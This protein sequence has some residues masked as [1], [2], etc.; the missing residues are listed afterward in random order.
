MRLKHQAY[1][2]LKSP[3]YLPESGCGIQTTVARATEIIATYQVNLLR[4]RELSRS[5]V[6]AKTRS[7]VHAGNTVIWDLLGTKRRKPDDSSVFEDLR[8]KRKNLLDR[9]PEELMG[10]I[11]LEL[12]AHQRDGS[13]TAASVARM[14]ADGKVK[15]CRSSVHLVFENCGYKYGPIQDLKY[16]AHRVNPILQASYKN[17]YAVA[18][19]LEEMG[20]AKIVYADETFINRSDCRSYGYTMSTFK[21]Q[22]ILGSERLSVFHAIT[23]DGL[24]VTDEVHSCLHIDKK[25]DVK[26]DCAV[27]HYIFSSV[28][29]TDAHK[30]VTAEDY[31]EYFIHRL[32]KAFKSKYPDKMMIL[33]LD[34]ALFHKGKADT[35]ISRSSSRKQLWDILRK[36]GESRYPTVKTGK[37]GVGVPIIITAKNALLTGKDCPNS[38]V[39][40][41]EIMKRKEH[42]KIA[43]FAK[44]M[45]AIEAEKSQ[46]FLLFT[47]PFD[48]QA[49]PIEL[50]WQALKE[51]ILGAKDFDDKLSVITRLV[52][53][54]FYL[55]EDTKSM[56]DLSKHRELCRGFIQRAQQY[57]FGDILTMMII[58]KDA[59]KMIAAALGEKVMDYQTMK[60]LLYSFDAMEAEEATEETDE[61]A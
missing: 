58:L 5:K 2:M 23:S 40:Y 15:A 16:P 55:D 1:R 13:V 34:N 17:R 19:A 43:P 29:K 57:V 26:S 25:D 37:K 53:Q 54:F 46:A 32:N 12:E 36:S 51:Y 61:T 48:P 47:P 60:S 41:K 39:I 7:E 22:K 31:K 8:S 56:V 49:Q 3:V 59:K 45:L 42:P 6:I 30:S 52:F 14:L 18:L 21:R 10:Q 27:G 38:E 33:I 35:A 4:C 24:L 28:E 11:K 44:G 9:I 20:F 50:F